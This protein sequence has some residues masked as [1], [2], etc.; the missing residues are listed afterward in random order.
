MFTWIMVALGAGVLMPNV[1]RWYWARFNGWGYLAGTATGMAL[2]LGQALYE[3]ATGVSL[4]VYQT[5]PAL[6]G[7]VLVVAVGVTLATPAVDD[8]TLKRFY[9]DVQPA[10]AWG[11]IAALVKHEDPAFR[12]EPFGVDLLNVC[13]GVPWIAGLYT[14]PT[15]LVAHQ[16][17]AAALVGGAVAVLTVILAFTWWPSLPPREPAAHGGQALPAEHAARAR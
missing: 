10:G 3:S 16:F 12:K 2:S 9:R 11:R 8:Q 17:T 5:F 7:I 4:P 13:I 14:A 6:A 1:L 15:L